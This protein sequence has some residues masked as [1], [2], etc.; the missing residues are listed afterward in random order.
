MRDKAARGTR[1]VVEVD[2]IAIRH[3]AIL[4]AWDRLE[5]LQKGIAQYRRSP[6]QDL[7]DLI[8]LVDVRHHRSDPKGQAA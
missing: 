5:C 4:H 3:I 7:G 6:L 1:D 8:V 2:A